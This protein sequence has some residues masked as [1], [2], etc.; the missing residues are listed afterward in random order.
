MQTWVV[1]R[2]HPGAGTTLYRG[3]DGGRLTTSGSADLGTPP[4]CAA[5]PLR[6]IGWPPGPAR[7]PM[8][9]CWRGETDNRAHPTRGMQ[10]V[11]RERLVG[12]A[13]TSASFACSGKA[14]KWALA[15]AGASAQWGGPRGWGSW[16][17]RSL[18]PG[19]V[20][21]FFLFLIPISFSNSYFELQF[22]S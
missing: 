4:P 3:E 13:V 1:K 18:G 5:S 11:E 14:E 10:R 6:R 19:S 20:L 15:S 2:M 22:Q 12:G 9:M 17:E 7:Q 16:D 8:L 21:L